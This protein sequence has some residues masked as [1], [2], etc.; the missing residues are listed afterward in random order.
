M[1]CVRTEVSVHT[2]GKKIRQQ[3]QGLALAYQQSAALMAAVESG[4]FTAVAKGADRLDSI[5]AKLAIT[6]VNAE[7]LVTACVAMGLLERDGE[8]F[9][10]APDVARFLVEGEP[11]YAGPWMLF[12]KPRWGEW[13]RLG[14]HLRR[15]GKPHVRGMA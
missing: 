14:E 15:T 9:V 8:R 2:Q 3:R 13:G 7:R 4:L 12:T 6:P 10:N 11:S 1:I 5:A